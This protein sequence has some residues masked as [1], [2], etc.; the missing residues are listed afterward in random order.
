MTGVPNVVRVLVNFDP[1]R[2]FICYAILVVVRAE[3]NVEDS[4]RRTTLQKSMQDPVDKHVAGENVRQLRSG[5]SCT[6]TAC[7]GVILRHG[8]DDN[9]SHHSHQSI[10]S[11]VELP[12]PTVING[13]WNYPNRS[14]LV[15][16]NYV[17][18]FN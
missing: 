10:Q 1:C 17:V 6:G 7:E 13:E 4:T 18:I 12:L 15:L 16:M 5:A 3:E 8:D 9:V 14:E 11:S 2:I